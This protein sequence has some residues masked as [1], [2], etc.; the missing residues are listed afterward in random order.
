MP[1]DTAH[2]IRALLAEHPVVDGHNDLPWEARE[3]VGYDWSRL[4]IAT[5]GQPTHTDL[6][7]LRA[8]GVGAQFWS[9]FVPAHLQGDAAVAATLE[10]VDAVHAM[11][12]RYAADLAL[13]TSVADVALA[14]SQG[15]IASLMGAEGGHS[16]DCS[17][18]TLRMLFAL[19]VR[20]LT[21]TH[22]DNVPWADS[23]TDE[24]VLG[25]LSPF[26]REVVREMNR[27]G[28]LVDLSHTSAGT[29]RDALDTTAAPVVFSHSSARAVCDHPRNVPDDVLERLAGN[30]GLCMVTFVPRFVSQAVRDWDLDADEAAAAEGIDTDDDGVH[31][32]WLA[33]RR[34][35]HRAPT[36]TLDDVVAHCEHVRDVAGVE[37]IGLGGDYDGVD[38]L[39]EGLED[40]SGYP[41]LLAAL[42]D[43]GWSDDDLARLAGG[44][45]LRVLGAAEE[46][47]REISVTRGASL[48]RI[49]DVDGIS[50]DGRA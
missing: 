4:D 31:D 15:R 28:M 42:A 40:V 19:G 37:H 5:A 35:T 24:P 22:N 41:R 33:R 30:G 23:A 1:S 43:R 34:R 11:T 17:M 21:L 27:L 32:P 2:R 6:P 7:R 9:V 49:E 50:A 36:A 3:R 14:R 44:N 13:A 12:R 29:M 8:G 20:Y 45:A 46:R 16:I 48:A 25:G 47:A 18:G 39:P 10:Q 38:V 26:G